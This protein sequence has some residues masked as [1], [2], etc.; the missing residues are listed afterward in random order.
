MCVC[1]MVKQ[2]RH[3]NFTEKNKRN[4]KLGKGGKRMWYIRKELK[5]IVVQ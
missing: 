4:K 2:W 3:R 1:V 5:W